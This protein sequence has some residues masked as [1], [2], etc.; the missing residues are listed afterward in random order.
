MT[1][2]IQWRN[3]VIDSSLFSVGF[4]GMRGWLDSPDM[5]S[6][7]SDRGGRHGQI[8]GQLLSSGRIFEVDW[9]IID[10]N[11]ATLRTMLA[12]TTPTENPA[13][14]PF[15][16]TSFEDFPALVT[17]AR[18]THWSVPTMREFFA[19]KRRTGTWQ[20][21]ATDPKI[22]NANSSTEVTALGTGGGSGLS[23]GPGGVA[24]PAAFGSQPTGGGVVVTNIGPAATWPVF[25]LDG[26][27]TGPAIT[28]LDTGRRLMFNPSFV[29]AAGQQV[30]IDTDAKT[31]LLNGVG[32]RDALTV[33]QW[34]PIDGDTTVH[35][36]FTAAA[37]EAGQLRVAWV[38]AWF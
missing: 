31:V 24:W 16:L 9:E 19:G 14:E 20:F 35:I 23:F 28:N 10:G 27:L 15:T 18:V 25:T 6:S 21:K 4:V 33:A 36:G 5:R 11:P 1:V 26:P 17:M 7:D 32:R 12:A 13:E 3:A 37:A 30:V 38:D 2:N 29:I 22:Y 8:P 34:F